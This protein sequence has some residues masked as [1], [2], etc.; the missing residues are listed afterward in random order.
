M[1]EMENNQTPDEDLNFDQAQYSQ[2]SDALARCQGCNQMLETL[3]YDINGQLVCPACKDNLNEFHDSKGGFK[4]FWKAIG[5]GLPAAALG[6]GIYYGISALTG[7]EFGLVAIVIGLLVGGAVK[8]GSSGR[9]GWKYQTLAIILTYMS[10]ASTYVPYAIEGLKDAHN[11]NGTTTQSEN[12][13]GATAKK[14]AIDNLTDTNSSD[15]TIAS[16]EESTE[17]PS[18]ADFGLGIIF[19]ILLAAALP[20]LAGIENAIGLLIIGFALYE[21]WKINKKPV[22]VIN[23]PFEVQAR[24]DNAK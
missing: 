18:I 20:V 22:F 24:D 7:Y 2:Q 13:A 3:Y 19:L 21:A 1:T 6:S 4:R 11:E 14:S 5:L 17:S 9:G 23:G 12:G 8:K 10:I 16:D 15:T